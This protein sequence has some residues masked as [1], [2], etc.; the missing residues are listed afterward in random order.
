MTSGL[1]DSCL[2]ALLYWRAMASIITTRTGMMT[3]TRSEAGALATSTTTET[4]PVITAPSALMPTLPRH[5]SPLTR[6][7]CLTIPPWLM[8]KLTKTPT[9]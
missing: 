6:S 4:M 5:L 2:P 9:E 3:A 1:T 8:V 7:Q